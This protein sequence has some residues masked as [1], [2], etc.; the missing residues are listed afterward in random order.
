M[1]G[2]VA[3]F[4][5]SNDSQPKDT[6]PDT[7]LENQAVS[8]TGVRGGRIVSFIS[9]LLWS[10]D[11]TSVDSNS[12]GAEFHQES[13]REYQRSV[14]QEPNDTFDK[15]WEDVDMAELKSKVSRY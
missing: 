6:G 1:A 8:S 10:G 9:G 15:S 2:W 3:K 12:R 5:P 4:L 11:D 14:F 7:E 13:G